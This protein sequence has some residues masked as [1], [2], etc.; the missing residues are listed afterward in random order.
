MPGSFDEETIGFQLWINLPKSKKLTDPDY[1]EIPKA[2]IPVYEMVISG[3]VLGVS[4]LTLNKK[5]LSDQYIF[6]S[7]G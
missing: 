4:S 3:E 2:S 7:K 6:N 5:L 1:Q